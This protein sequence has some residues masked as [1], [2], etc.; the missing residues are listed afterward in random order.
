MKMQPGGSKRAARWSPAQAKRELQG[1]VSSGISLTAYSR[2]RGYSEKTLSNWRSRLKRKGW[3][4]TAVEK[5]VLVPVRVVDGP[6]TRVGSPFEVA[7]GNGVQVRVPPDFESGS[8]RRLL[9]VV[10][11]C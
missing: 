7:L 3:E 8:L 4:P 9:Q 11:E 1:W 2:Q 5:P 10:A 6:R